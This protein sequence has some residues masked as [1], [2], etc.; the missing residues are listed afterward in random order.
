MKLLDLLSTLL[1]PSSQAVTMKLPFIG[2][3][4]LI[5]GSYSCLDGLPSSM[6][7]ST[8]NITH[9]VGYPSMTGPPYSQS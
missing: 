1:Y 9:S 7:V 5:K 6:H 8:T 4:G 2:E 3:S